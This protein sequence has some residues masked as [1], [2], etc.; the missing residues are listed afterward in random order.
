MKTDFNKN[1][2]TFLQ[3]GIKIF[4]DEYKNGRIKLCLNTSSISEK[5]F[6]SAVKSLKKSLDY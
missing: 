5:D 6:D 4:I 1:T 2:D 3:N